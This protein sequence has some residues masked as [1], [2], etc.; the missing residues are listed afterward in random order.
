MP[1]PPI[2]WLDG[3]MSSP[4]SPSYCAYATRVGVLNARL[5]Y[6]GVATRLDGRDQSPSMFV[7][8]S[9]DN[10]VTLGG[11]FGFFLLLPALEQGGS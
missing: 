4:I 6:G 10:P 3:F 8:M 1:C 5:S 7:A 9:L 11:L 2:P